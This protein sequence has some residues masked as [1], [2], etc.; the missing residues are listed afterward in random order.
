ML[1]PELG[2]ARVLNRLSA[3]SVQNL[4]DPGR[5]ADGGGLYFS[6]S[7]DGQRRRWVFLFRWKSPG[8]TGRGKLREKGLGSAA[9]VSLA[10]ARELAAAARAEVA[11]GRDP[12]AARAT[13]RAKPTF[14]QVA[15][16]VIAALEPGW[17]NPKH[18]AQWRSTVSEY[19]KPIAAKLVDEVNTD[20]VLA[21]LKPLWSR[22]P[23][24]ASRLRGRIE[25]ILDAAKARGMRA[26]EN[27]ARWRGHL[28]HLLPKPSKLTRGHHKALPYG[29][30]PAFMGRLGQSGSISA[31]CLQ[32]TILTAARSGEAMGA[33][34]EE[35]DFDKAVWIVPA[36]RMKAGREHRVPLSEPALAI[37]REMAAV[38]TGPFVFSGQKRG[39]PLS[40]MALEMVL[41]RMAVDATVHGFRSSFRDWV[42]EQTDTAGEVAEAALAHTIGNK[43][44]AAYRRSDLFDKRRALMN[45]WADHCVG[46]ERG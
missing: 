43:V 12:L 36:A 24:T 15:E 46:P 29:E 22:V 33:I 6:I 11:A 2:M 31:L 5:H 34:W 40:T 16:E 26:G 4:K 38:R 42:A 44:E 30:I 45:A 7:P 27:P 37:L 20:D 8:S 19:C 13:E 3:R 35:I 25:T 10:R 28:D 21:I 9:T 1:G 14:H 18:R 41:R 17:R 23:E 39:L 32:F